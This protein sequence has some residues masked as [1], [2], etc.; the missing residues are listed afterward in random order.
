MSSLPDRLR[1][2]GGK[3][4]GFRRSRPY[5]FYGTASV[6]AGVLLAGVLIISLLVYVQRGGGGPMPTVTEMV[7][8]RNDVGSDLLDRRGGKLGR[9]YAENRSVCRYE[10]LPDHLVNALIVTEDARF[11]DHGGV[12]W[13]AYGRVLWKTVLRGEEDQGGGSTITQQLVKNVYGRPRLGHHPKI[14]LC[15]HKVREAILARRL[16]SALTKDE[17][18]ERYLNTVSFPGNTFG[19]A[20]VS[21]RYF[22]KNPG[23]LTPREAASLVASLKGSTTY[24]PRRAPA[25]NRERADR[26]LD[27]MAAA[28]HLSPTELTAVKADSLMLNYRRENP[29]AGIAPHFTEAVRLRAQELLR[30]LPHPREDRS[31]NLYTDNLR[32]IT[33]LD[34]GMQRHAEAAL[35]EELADHQRNFER[36]L[37]NRTP[38]A[39]EA[40]LMAA[41]RSSNRFRR[42]RAAGRDSAAIWREFNTPVATE[43]PT[44]NGAIIEGEFSPLDSVAHRLK[45]L[46]AGLLALDHTDGA[47][48]AWVGGSD[49]NFNRYDNV[50][51]R[52]QTGSTFKPVV[53][54]A[55]IQNGY[56]PC[57]T[58]PNDLKTYGQEADAWTPRNASGEYGGRYSMHGALSHSINTAAVRMISQVGPQKVVRL[59]HDLGIR[60][61]LP[62][63]LGI[64]LGTIDGSLLQMTGAYTAFANGGYFS[65][66]YLIARIETA[67]GATVY[68]HE[69]ARTRVLSEEQAQTMNEMLRYVVDRGTGGRLRWQHHVKVPAT[70]KTGTTQNMADGWFIG[71]T[72]ALTGGV[73]VG[74]ENN[75]VRFRSGHGGNGSRSALPIWAS[76]LK[77]MENDTAM[78]AALGANFPVT[79]A[80]VKA[81]FYCPEFEPEEEELLE[82]EALNERMVP[83][84]AVAT[85]PRR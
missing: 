34:P 24:D 38:W 23:E 25:R 56:S 10:D 16:E 7:A 46:R 73:W 80:G 39:T 33:T 8:Y 50:T 35:R 6:L 45:Y 48:R 60:E 74:G 36:H 52:R 58:L 37:G 21:K 79:S 68:E 29:Y 14:D 5:L 12:D 22:Q 62:E 28:G 19:I 41:V 18:I 53:Y 59:A 40:S 63:V 30:V 77:R 3:L 43:L 2:F 51:S 82:L 11:R 26:T 47:V 20:A 32:I 27:L 66:P 69:G 84:E 83:V 44:P 64:A 42:A 1:H 75:G 49:F 4:S 55:A 57:H 9:F 31:W 67:D 71:S 13:R 81:S 85:E 54:A 78:V 15:L 65:E 61:E 17:I 70:G 72:P 76:F